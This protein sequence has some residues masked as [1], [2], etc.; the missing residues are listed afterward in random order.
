[1]SEDTPECAKLH[2]L[3]DSF[4]ENMAP[5]PLAMCSKTRRPQILSNSLKFS[6]ILSNSLKFS[7]ILSNSLKFSQILSNSLKFSQKMIP[8]DMFEY[9]ITPF[10]WGN[11]CIS[12]ICADNAIIITFLLTMY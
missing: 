8:N 10:S 5:N 1:M 9:G 7:Q 4:R 2:H 12:H 6:Q 11:I 3:K